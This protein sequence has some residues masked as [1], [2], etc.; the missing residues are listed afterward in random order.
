MCTVSSIWRQIFLI[1]LSFSSGSAAEL[2]VAQGR[3]GG[4][5]GVAAGWASQQD[6]GPYLE[7]LR[8]PC[9]KTVWNRAHLGL[10]PYP[11]D[12]QAAEVAR[13]GSVPRAADVGQG[14]VSWTCLADPHRRHQRRLPAGPGRHRRPSPVRGPGSTEF[15]SENRLSLPSAFP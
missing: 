13:L 9:L 8:T 4:G 1:D 15:R 10:M 7:F 6:V 2:M 11:G 12:D 5:T 3:A 14:D